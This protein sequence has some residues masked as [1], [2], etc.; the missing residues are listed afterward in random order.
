MSDFIKHIR[1]THEERKTT[2]WCGRELHNY[3]WA[4]ENIDHAA[5]SSLSRGSVL[6]CQKCVAAVAKA[7][8][9]PASSPSR[10]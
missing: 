3:D 8:E 9:M 4:F 10:P 2:A 5:Y 7:F 1:H 6:P